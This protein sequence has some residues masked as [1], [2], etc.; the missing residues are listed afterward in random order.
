[1]P[2]IIN[3]CKTCGIKI[4]YR[5]TYCKKH[6]ATKETKLKMSEARKGIT[7][8]NKNKK[9]VYK[10]SDN[11]KKKFSID[12]KKRGSGKWMKGR[13]IPIDVKEKMRISI[14]NS[15]LINRFT[16][17]IPKG[18]LHWN[19]KGGLSRDKHYSYKAKKWRSDVFE[20][21]NW[22]CQTC[23][24]RGCYLEA[25]H[26]KSWSKFPE[27]RYK[28]DNGITLCNECHKLTDNYKGK[29]NR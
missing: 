8:W 22:T 9:G 12:A 4:D 2:D 11:I 27:L 7:P 29:A 3:K 5:S 25:H 19:W 18:E 10:F 13:K 23:G 24:T 6:F 26:I 16:R 15:W 17:K 28:I 14:K 1:M 20:R 21:D